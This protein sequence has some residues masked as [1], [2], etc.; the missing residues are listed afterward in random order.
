MTRSH[1]ATANA[2]APPRSDRDLDWAE[3]VAAGVDRG[4][5]GP[6]CPP[7]PDGHWVG[8]LEGDTILESEFILL[9]AFL[10]KHDDP[11]IRLAANYLLHEATAR[12]AAGPNYPGGP[13]E[14][15]VSV[16]AY[17]ALKIAGHAADAPHMM[18]GRDTP[19]ATSAARRPPTRSRAST[20]RCSANCRTPR[21]RRSRPN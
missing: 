12:T 21:A 20:S 6:H 14:V 9:L 7:R 11:R 3:E 2:Q 16:K 15:S 19:S 10:G 1:S 18:R 17:F 13:A 4:R 5:I 8:E